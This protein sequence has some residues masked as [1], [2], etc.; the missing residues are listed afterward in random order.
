MKKLPPC[1]ID[2]NNQS[3]YLLSRAGEMRKTLYEQRRLRKKLLDH[4][5]RCPICRE[6]Y[7]K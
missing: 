1:A 2:E 5:R 6:R 3:D 4:Q 7:K